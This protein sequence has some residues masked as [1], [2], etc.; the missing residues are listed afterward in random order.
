MKKSNWEKELDIIL[1][2]E[3]RYGYYHDHFGHN[4]DFYDAKKYF[5]KLE[6]I[7]KNKASI[8]IKDECTA[9]I[10][11]PTSLKLAND[12]LLFIMTESP[13]PSLSK[14]NDKKRLLT[15]EWDY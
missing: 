8:S 12:I 13:S 7:A 6:K 9:T 14:Y 3:D 1:S 10:V 15:L 4:V 5:R 2:E 11:M